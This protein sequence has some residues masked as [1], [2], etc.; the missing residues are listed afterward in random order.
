M[1]TT[2]T[3]LLELEGENIRFKNRAFSELVDKAKAELKA[4]SV[5]LREA[6]AKSKD[7]RANCVSFLSISTEEGS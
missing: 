5:S 1:K 7:S 4:H 6:T 3:A 2:G